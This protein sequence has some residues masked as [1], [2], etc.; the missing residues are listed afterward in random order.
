MTGEKCIGW[1]RMPEGRL[2]PLAS[3]Y[4]ATDERGRTVYRVCLGD[5][6]GPWIEVKPRIDIEAEEEA[7]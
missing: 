7:A 4:R 3:V 5:F 1:Q 6:A 2:E